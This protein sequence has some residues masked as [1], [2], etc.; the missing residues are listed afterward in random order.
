MLKEK[1]ELN[2][3]NLRVSRGLVKDSIFAFKNFY[4]SLKTSLTTL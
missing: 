3:N 2:E 4:I 1:K